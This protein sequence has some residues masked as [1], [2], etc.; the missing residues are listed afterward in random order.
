M[1][2]QFKQIALLPLQ[3]VVFDPKDEVTQQTFLTFNETWQKLSTL[4]TTEQVFLGLLLQLPNTLLSRRFVWELKAHIADQLSQDDTPGYG[5]NTAGHIQRLDTH[6]RPFFPGNTL[7]AHVI[8]PLCFAIGHT[9]LTL[10]ILSSGSTVS[11]SLSAIADASTTKPAFEKNVIVIGFMEFFFTLLILGAQL[12]PLLATKYRVQFGILK[13]Y[14]PASV[15]LVSKNKNVLGD[16]QDK[17]VPKTDT[18]SGGAPLVEARHGVLMIERPSAKNQGVIGTA[19]AQPGQSDNTPPLS[20]VLID[21]FKTSSS[22][23][24]QNPYLAVSGRFKTIKGTIQTEVNTPHRIQSIIDHLSGIVPKHLSV[25]WDKTALTTFLSKHPSMN[26]PHWTKLYGALALAILNGDKKITEGHFNTIENLVSGTQFLCDITIFS[27]RY[28]TEKISQI[29]DALWFNDR[30]ENNKN[31]QRTNQNLLNNALQ[32]LSETM[33]Q[34]PYQFD[35]IVGHDDAIKRYAGIVQLNALLQVYWEKI[36]IGYPNHASIPELCV[37]PHIGIILEGGFS[38]GKSNVL[39]R[40]NALNEATLA[41]LRQTHTVQKPKTYA[42]RTATDRVV[43]KTIA[44]DMYPKQSIW[45]LQAIPYGLKSIN[46][47]LLI[48]ATAEILS[49]IKE[50]NK[51]NSFLLLSLLPISFAAL[52]ACITI[53]GHYAVR[54]H[55]LK[56]G[57]DQS[58]VPLDAPSARKDIL[59]GT[60]WVSL[61]NGFRYDP[62]PQFRTLL[63]PDKTLGG[64]QKTLFVEELDKVISKAG[65]DK[66]VSQKILLALLQRHTREMG[67][68]QERYRLLFLAAA[69]DGSLVNT[70]FN[71]ETVSIR[72]TFSERFRITPEHL[73]NTR[74]RLLGWAYAFAHSAK[75]NVTIYDLKTIV[76]NILSTNPDDGHVYGTIHRE[77]AKNWV[78]RL[79]PKSTQSPEEV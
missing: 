43:T 18:W 8:E 74:A 59:P 52:I 54:Q 71:L 60:E 65:A 51:D 9:L 21:Y 5:V 72:E 30:V 69:N 73:K 29:I 15:I 75:K 19:L 49:E 27:T 55:Q 26:Q 4:N 61:T 24:T 10:A 37:P 79:A 45:G 41:K 70:E 50:K 66:T 3:D 63:S 32:T 22:E 25:A 33:V 40:L 28:D 77:I 14:G 31:T 2:S 23:T 17:D 38:A 48:L 11:E 7:A 12:I 53:G 36:S 20:A 64:I 62:N 13:P 68:I 16:Q 67:P 39:Y 47:V 56:H 76:D 57:L 1:Y 42:E 58:I 6:H 34:E 46:A 44:A 78:L 35:H